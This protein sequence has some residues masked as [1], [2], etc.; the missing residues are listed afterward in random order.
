MDVV[1]RIVAE[2]LKPLAAGI[3]VSQV[4]R[5][6]EHLDSKDAGGWSNKTVRIVHCAY[7]D[8]TYD[9]PNSSVAPYKQGGGA[10]PGGTHS[11]S[12][13]ASSPMEALSS[14]SSR[15][16][17]GRTQRLRPS[18]DNASLP[19]VAVMQATFSMDC[20]L[21]NILADMKVYV[22]EHHG[23]LRLLSWLPQGHVD[24]LKDPSKGERMLRQWLSHL[25]V[26]ACMAKHTEAYAEP[27]QLPGLD[28][29][30]ESPETEPSSGFECFV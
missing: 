8:A 16:N 4:M 23:S 11:V 22:V 12:M 2:A 26:D 30:P 5:D 17:S 6:V 14:T 25:Y 7:L 24:A 20:E 28:E 13:T 27:P 18:Y 29:W 19:D 3:A 9:L 21:V 10:S 1:N 15:R